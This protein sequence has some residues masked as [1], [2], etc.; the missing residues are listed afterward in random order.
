MSALT[1]FSFYFHLQG[2]YVEFNI[3]YVGYTH[4]SRWGP[5]YI[6]DNSTASEIITTCL[7]KHFHA[8]VEICPVNI[9][10]RGLSSAGD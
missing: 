3:I 4:I 8:T 2:N 7:S 6:F 9:K 5:Y 1:I 10:E